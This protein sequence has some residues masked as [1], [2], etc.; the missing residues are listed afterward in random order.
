[1]CTVLRTTGAKAETSISTDVRLGPAVKY[2]R[3]A[4]G[5][6]RQVR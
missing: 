1:M 4:H 6:I 3:D 5:T 2:V